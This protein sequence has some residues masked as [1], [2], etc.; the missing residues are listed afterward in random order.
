MH[1]DVARPG[2]GDVSL[3]FTAPS[4]EQEMQKPPGDVSCPQ[5]IPTSALPVLSAPAPD[6]GCMRTPCLLPIN[7]EKRAKYRVR[8]PGGF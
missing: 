5:A 6:T 3:L 1:W 4:E 8:V 7:K 2:R